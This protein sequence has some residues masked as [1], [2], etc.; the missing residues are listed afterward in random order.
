MHIRNVIALVVILAALSVAPALGDEV[1]P[2]VLDLTVRLH[3]EEHVRIEFRPSVAEAGYAI[4]RRTRPI[5]SA[6]DLDDAV[7]LE[8]T[9]GRNTVRFDAPPPGLPYYYAVV[10][11]DRLDR[12]E[13]RLVP[14]RSRTVNPITIELTRRDTTP[15]SPRRPELRRVPLPELLVIPELE[16]GA[17]IDTAPFELHD[18]G[19]L[20]D[21]LKPAFKTLRAAAPTAPAEEPPQPRILAPERSR[22]TELEKSRA[23]TLA[24]VVRS[25]FEREEWSEAERELR[26]LATVLEDDATRARALYYLGQS[27]YFQER[28]HEAF[29]SFLAAEPELYPELQPWLTRVLRAVE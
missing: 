21:E 10:A 8:I 27:L 12:G 14:G 28:Y 19:P 11:L 7:R 24:R 3:G 6:E 16:S 25:R 18:A 22:I 29:M 26:S 15:R 5:R 13:A 9:T 17:T 2:E 4:Y 1:P 23:A 20:T